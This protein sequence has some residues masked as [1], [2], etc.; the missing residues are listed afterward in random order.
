MNRLIKSKEVYWCKDDDRYVLV[1]RE[2]DEIV[3]LNYMQGDDWE[4]FESDYT[5]IDE[6]LTKFYNCIK[7]MLNGA[8]EIDRINQAIWAYFAYENN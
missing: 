7:G 8:T 5:S 3:G 4:L 1:V 2:H 6:N